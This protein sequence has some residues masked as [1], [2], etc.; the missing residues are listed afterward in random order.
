MTAED[1]LSLAS[2]FVLAA[3]SIPLSNKLT[4]HE[5]LSSDYLPKDIQDELDLSQI[6]SQEILKVA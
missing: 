4:T 5:R 3:L 1:K 6:V 2:E